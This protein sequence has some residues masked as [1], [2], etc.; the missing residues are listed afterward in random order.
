MYNL[1]SNPYAESRKL[2]FYCDFNGTAVT[3]DNIQALSIDSRIVADDTLSIGNTCST[4]VTITMAIPTGLAIHD[5][6]FVLYFGLKEGNTWEYIPMGT[7]YVSTVS[8]NDDGVTSSITA[9]DK[10]AYM[11]ENFSTDSDTLNG[12]INDIATKYSLVLD[13]SV[14]IPSIKILNY[15]ECNDRTMLG[16]LASLMGMNAY[17]TREGKLSFKWFNSVGHAVTNDSILMDGQKNFASST[18]SVSALLLKTDTQQFESG[19][20]RN[21]EF[22]NPLFDYLLEADDTEFDIQEYLDSLKTSMLPLTYN[23]NE[24]AFRGNPSLDLGDVITFN[25]LSTPLMVIKYDYDGGL[26]SS[27][28]SYGVS[29]NSLSITEQSYVEKQINLNRSILENAFEQAMETMKGSLGG[30]WELVYENEVPYGWRIYSNS[31]RSKYWEFSFSGMGFFE[32]GVLTKTAITNDGQIVANAIT[33]GTL[34]SDRIRVGGTEAIPDSLGTFF[35]V[36][37]E[38]GEYVVKLGKADSSIILKEYNDSV[39][40]FNN[41]GDLLAE[42]TPTGLEFKTMDNIKM[43]DFKIYSRYFG[44]VG[45]ESKYNLSFI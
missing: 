41:N 40:F 38:N 17:I 2:T 14:A 42:F 19:E 33:T 1:T 8:T 27:V 28:Y 25:S 10:M 16:Y 7:F 29:T 18:Y 44:E 12:M 37:K 35:S 20:G 36:D 13:D 30:Y 32:N 31:D 3:S 4:Q 5:A 11:S 24:V 39:G 45:G 15:P 34:S 43:G 9:Y 23:A 6:S 21:L 26:T 22:Y